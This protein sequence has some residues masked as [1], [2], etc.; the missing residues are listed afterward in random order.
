MKP[1]ELSVIVPTY[2]RATLLRRCLDALDKQNFPK[3]QYEV[4]VVDDGS[5]DETR[6]F[7]SS[8][9]YAYNLRPIF[10]D[11]GGA[12]KA[13]NRGI[14]ESLGEILVFT[15]DDCFPQP[16]FLKLHWEAH[17]NTKDRVARGPIIIIRTPDEEVQLHQKV[18]SLSM[19]F[20]CTSNASI[21]RQNLLKAGLFDE[22]FPRW[23]DAELGYRLRKAGLRYHFDP[24]MI[25]LHL[26]PP[27]KIKDLVRTALADGRSARQL[28]NAHPSLRTWFSCGLHP[29]NR[30]IGKLF[31]PFAKRKVNAMNGE[32][33][34]EGFWE[35]LIFQAYFTIGLDS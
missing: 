23:E 30:G 33:V 31:L 14:R 9:N 17:Q 5:S 7:L 29:F 32:N 13:R 22:T 8:S 1:P 3:E 2:N 16:N 34:I 24:S 21:L 26:K 25:V 27:W 28:Y 20:F 4:M 11:H 15:D 18:A 10:A 19:N 35:H 6:A 12:A